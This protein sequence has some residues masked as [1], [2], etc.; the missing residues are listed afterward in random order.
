MVLK[1][2][3]VPSLMT[4]FSGLLSEVTNSPPDIY[5]ESMIYTYKPVPYVITQ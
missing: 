4:K 1:I 2:H 5:S 3:F